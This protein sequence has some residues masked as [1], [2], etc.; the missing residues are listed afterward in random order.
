LLQGACREFQKHG[1]RKRGCCRVQGVPI[2]M[3]LDRRIA[4]GCREFQK[5]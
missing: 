3:G 5:T 1:T 4:A 2:N